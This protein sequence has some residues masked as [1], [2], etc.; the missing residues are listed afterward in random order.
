[1]FQA[2]NSTAVGIREALFGRTV[3]QSIWY[4][5]STSSRK[6]CRITSVPV[7][8]RIFPFISRPHR[9]SLLSALD[10][11][12][13]CPL[14]LL[15]CWIVSHPSMIIPCA[16]HQ[17]SLKLYLLIIR[18]RLLPRG[19]LEFRSEKQDLSLTDKSIFSLRADGHH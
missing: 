4:R 14:V 6:H 10:S 5:K 18:W 16:G 19:T 1:M 8:T 7:G 11:S 3:G 13:P 9:H 17:F 15:R 2:M 12:H